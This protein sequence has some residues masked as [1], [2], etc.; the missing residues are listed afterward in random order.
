MF[1][2]IMDLEFVSALASRTAILRVDTGPTEQGF[3]GGVFFSMPFRP[4]RVIACR[5]T[6]HAS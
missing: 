3:A 1:A 5:L 6:S 2:A 4:D